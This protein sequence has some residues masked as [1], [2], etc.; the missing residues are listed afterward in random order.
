MERLVCFQWFFPSP[1][2]SGGKIIPAP[3]EAVL[4]RDELKDTWLFKE[5]HPQEVYC[6]SLSPSTK[7]GE[8]GYSVKAEIIIRGTERN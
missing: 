5:K 7:N 6:V 4:K 1:T 3:P 8:T 2:K